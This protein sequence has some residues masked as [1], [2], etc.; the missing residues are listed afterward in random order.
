MA[1]TEMI[2]IFPTLTHSPPGTLSSTPYLPSTEHVVRFSN[3]Q[4]L[5]EM[6][7]AIVDMEIASAASKCKCPQTTSEAPKHAASTEP[8]TFKDVEELI[9]KL[10]DEKSANSSASD[11]ELDNQYKLME[12]IVNYTILTIQ[13]VKDLLKEL[14]DASRRDWLKFQTVL[15]P[16]PRMLRWLK[17]MPTTPKHSKQLKKCMMPLLNERDLADKPFRYSWDNKTYKYALVEPAKSWES[18]SALSADRS[19]SRTIF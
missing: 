7:K 18:N 16:I 12:M 6:V 8:L 13:D 9:L 14:V 1:P 2:Q 5:F 10:I 4:Q 3:V 17:L 19:L 11:G 15:N